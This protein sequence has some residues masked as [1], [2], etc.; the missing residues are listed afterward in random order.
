MMGQFRE[1][2]LNT[3]QHYNELFG[4]GRYDSVGKLRME[5]IYK[6]SIYVCGPRILDVG[7]G[8]GAAANWFA[9]QGYDAY[10]VDFSF[11]AIQNARKGWASGG[12]K[13][14]PRQF[15]KTGIFTHTNITSGLPWR[16]GYFD[17]AL[18]I[19][20]LEHMT[21]PRALAQEIM[22]VLRPCG[23]LF[24]T[25]PKP[26]VSFQDAEHKWAF[27]KADYR[28]LFDTYRIMLYSDLEWPRNI[29]GVVEKRRE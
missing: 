22:R 13:E 3:P 8:E 29:W 7:C 17:S 18:A 21:D 16:D 19:E 10:G 5:R 14:K 11:T 28:R 20:V 9:E 12:T 6:A 4:S 24:F 25:C 15:T 23:R 2:D 27:E 26:E 1:N